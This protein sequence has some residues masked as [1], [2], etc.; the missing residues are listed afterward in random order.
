MTTGYDFNHEY[1]YRGRFSVS[2]EIR[3]SYSEGK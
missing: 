3:V 1:E 2:F